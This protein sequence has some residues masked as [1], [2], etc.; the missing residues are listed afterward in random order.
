M[1]GNYCETAYSSFETLVIRIRKIIQTYR[2]SRASMRQPYQE[3]H[4]PLIV[5]QTSFSFSYASIP[6]APWQLNMARPG[7]QILAHSTPIVDPPNYVA[8][9]RIYGEGLIAQECYQAAD[10]LPHGA[11]P[12][13]YQ[14]RGRDN[15]LPYYTIPFSIQQGMLAR[16]P[17]LFL[18]FV[19]CN[20]R[21]LIITR[22][23]LY[24][25]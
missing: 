10:R 20:A 4:T 16:S 19:L 13:A 25:R 14:V 1:S 3:N 22:R 7:W 9:N 21:I 23:V 8:C 17:P 6:S 2:F 12:R 18:Q 15:P 11:N 24:L 5:F